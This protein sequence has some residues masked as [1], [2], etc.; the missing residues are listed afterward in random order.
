MI[1]AGRSG[2]VTSS[3]LPGFLR[4]VTKP[5]FSKAW[6][7]RLAVDVGIPLRLRARARQK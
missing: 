3:P 1:L 6:I 4:I 2:S 5:F 7:A